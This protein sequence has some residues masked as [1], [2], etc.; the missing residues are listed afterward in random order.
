MLGMLSR[1]SSG[2]ALQSDQNN[3]TKTPNKDERDSTKPF[4]N[5]GPVVS[6]L[7][8]IQSCEGQDGPTD[9]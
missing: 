8:V 4:V 6:E 5:F 2:F 1:L 9:R 3:G 7:C